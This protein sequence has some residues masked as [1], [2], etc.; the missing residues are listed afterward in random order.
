MR[1]PVKTE[2]GEHEATGAPLAEPVSSR[3]G[4]PVHVD[5]F[6]DDL[7]RACDYMS[8]APVTRQQSDPTIAQSCGTDNQRIDDDVRVFRC[9]FELIFCVANVICELD[10]IYELFDIFGFASWILFFSCCLNIFGFASWISLFL[11]LFKIFL[12][13]RVGFIFSLFFR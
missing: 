7:R 1:A 2:I 10:V 5:A 9:G 8:R 6:D 3:K 11:C 4:S 13:L 12:V